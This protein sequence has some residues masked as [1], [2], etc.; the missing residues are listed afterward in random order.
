M[1]H[2]R[3]VLAAICLTA[4]LISACA[5]TDGPHSRG[6]EMSLRYAEVVAIERVKMP[7]QAPVGA[8]LGGF[9][10]LAT[11]GGRSGRTTIGRAAGG[12][13]IGAGVAKVVEGDRLGYAYDLRFVRGG[14]SRFVT[15]KGF[16]E[17]GDCVAVERGQYANLRRVASSY[18]AGDDVPADVKRLQTREAKQ[19]DAAKQQLLDADSEEAISSAARK[20]EL[21]CQY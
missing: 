10:G 20:V 11:S 8:M 19:C 15:E 3:A 6:Q 14:D 12:A 21:I 16:L 5:S 1:S 4:V 13:L 17:V 18:C 7:S 2:T 9:T